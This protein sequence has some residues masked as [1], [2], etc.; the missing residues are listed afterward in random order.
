MANLQVASDGS[1]DFGGAKH[2][3]VALKRLT[4]AARSRIGAVFGDPKATPILIYADDDSRFGW[5]RANRVGS[6]ACVVIGPEGRSVDVV[7]HELMHAELHHRVGWRRR[8]TQIPTW[9]DEG[10]AMQVDWRRRYLL[11]REDLP[12]SRDVMDR[13]TARAFF[14]AD[15]Q[16]LTRNYAEARQV[17]TDWLNNAGAETLYSRL[18]QLREGHS[19]DEM[20]SR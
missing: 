14:V 3:D 11:P 19:F 2:D 5:S 16:A 7:A 10:I 6:R 8:L 13:K 20:L 12:R 17:V 4:Q 9:F 15:D 1:T 18:E